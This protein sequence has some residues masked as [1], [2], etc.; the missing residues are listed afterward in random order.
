MREALPDRSRLRAGFGGEPLRQRAGTDPRCPGRLVRRADRAITI[1]AGC[2]SGTRTPPLPRPA[3]RQVPDPQPLH[4]DAQGQVVIAD[5]SRTESQHRPAAQSLDYQPPDRTAAHCANPTTTASTRT[6]KALGPVA[7]VRSLERH[8]LD[9]LSDGPSTN[10]VTNDSEHIRALRPP[11]RP[12][13]ARTRR[14]QLNRAAN[15]HN[16]PLGPSSTSHLQLQRLSAD[17]GP[18]YTSHTSATASCE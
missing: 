13:R 3:A 16:S 18:T 17:R 15:V 4:D 7:G 6:L 10:C 5:S 9:R 8:S 1:D 12:L 14:I 2:A 11:L